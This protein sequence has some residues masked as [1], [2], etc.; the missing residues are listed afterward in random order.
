LVVA[1]D[2]GVMCRYLDEGIIVAAIVYP[3]VLLREK[4]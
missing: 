2:G 3:L 1:G 4:P